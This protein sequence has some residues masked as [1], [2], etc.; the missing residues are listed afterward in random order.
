MNAEKKVKML[1]KIAVRNF[2]LKHP[3]YDI[4]S[5]FVEDDRYVCTNV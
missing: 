1:S 2:F 3:A 4:K 5:L